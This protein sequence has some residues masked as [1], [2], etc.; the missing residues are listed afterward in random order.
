MSFVEMNEA[1]KQRPD[2]I[3][4]LL[5]YGYSQKEMEI[6]QQVAGSLDIDEIKAIEPSMQNNLV[7]DILSGKIKKS[8]LLVP[9]DERVIIFNDLSDYDIHSF[10]AAYK[11]TQLPRP[12]YAVGTIHSRQ[13]PFSD[14]IKELIKERAEM[15]RQQFENK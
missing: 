10:I 9:I 14:W 8:E 13:W 2:G 3:P 15:M 5:V 12:I 11:T 1:N 4:C 6:V 7:G